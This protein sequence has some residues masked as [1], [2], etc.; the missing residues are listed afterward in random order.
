MARDIAK[1]REYKRKWMAQRRY[2]FFKDKKCT[3]CGSVDSLQL[4]HINPE[5]KEDHKIWSWREERRL[6]EI[7]K[8]EVLCRDCHVAH[9]VSLIPVPDHGTLTRYQ[10]YKCRC[11]LC[12]AEN[13][14]RELVRRKKIK[15]DK[16]LNGFDKV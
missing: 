15:E 3:R 1:Q 6:T 5:E 9:H 13:S 7:Q 8:C 2:D 12:R 16:G 14:R 11:D 4:H 10:S